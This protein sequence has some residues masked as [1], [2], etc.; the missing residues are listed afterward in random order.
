MILDSKPILRK[1]IIL[2]GLLLYAGLAAIW[3]IG[4]ASSE[5]CQGIEVNI[6]R[7]SP[8]AAALNKESVKQEL[9]SLAQTYGKTPLGKINTQKLEDK[10]D[11]VNN[12]ERV[13]CYINSQG[14]LVV[15]VVPMIPVARIFT[16]YDSYYINES[17]KRIDARPEYYADVPVVRGNFT[18][19]MPAKLVVPVIKYVTSDSLLNSLVS[20][21]DYESPRDIWIIPRIKGHVVNIG[22]TTRLKEKFDNLRLFYRKVMP[23]KGWNY[24]DI[25]YLKYKGQVVGSRRNKELPVHGVDSL[26]YDDTEDTDDIPLEDLL[27]AS[28]ELGMKNGSASIKSSNP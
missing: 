25:I 2:I 14:K 28:V 7:N 18:P 1:W 6:M 5:K 4:K 15:N 27:P 17:G 9:G 3:A 19:N 22:D 8:F 23:V 13:E 12:F 21:I 20:M 10:L 16:G 26:D 11:K 24:Y